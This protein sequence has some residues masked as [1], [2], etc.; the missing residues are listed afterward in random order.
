MNFDKYDNSIFIV[1]NGSKKGIIKKIRKTSK[2]LN[3]KVLSLTELKKKWY[4]DYSKDAI[5]YVSKKYSV[6]SE[7]AKIYI[8]NLYYAKEIDDEKMSFL[9]SLKKELD[10]NNL[11]KTSPLF[12]KFMHDKTIVLYDLDNVDSF[13]KNIFNKLGKSNNVIKYSTSEEGTPKELY[14]ASNMFEEVA[15]VTSSIVKLVKNGVDINN[16][17][18]ANV[19]DEY[20]FVI[21]KTFKDF[22]IPVVLPNKSSIIGTIIVK[23]FIELYSNNMSMVFENLSELVKD[24][25]DEKIYQSLL[26]II[27]DYSW[28]DNYNNVKDMLLSDIA[29]IKLPEKKLKNAVRVIDFLNDFIEEDTH[30]F[31]INF[32]QGVLP[33]DHKDEDYLSDELKQKIGIS[34]SIELNVKDIAETQK[35][36]R[37]TKN[38]VVTYSKHSLSSELYIS[39]AYSDDLFIEKQI[40][41]DYTLSNNYNKSLLTS[42]LDNYK[43]YGKVTQDLNILYN[44]YKEFDYCSYNSEYKGIEKNKIQDKLG[45]KLVLS[46]TSMNTYYECAFKYYLEYILKMNKFEDSFQI[47]IGNI[48]HKILSVAFTD[49]FDFDY[50]WNKTIEEC[51]Y[52]FSNMEKFFLDNLKQEL[53]L[54]IDTI[55]NQLEYTT[56]KNAL[57]EEEV[58][59]E[60]DKNINLYFKGFIDKILYKEED[61]V[62]YVVIID[63]KT[64]NTD[65]SLAGIPHGLNMQL[66]VYIYLLKNQKIIKNVRIGGFYLQRILDDITDR[67]K[68]LDSLKLIGYSNSDI[69]VLSKVDSSYENSKVIKSLK[70]T[71][72]GFSSYSKLLS[73]NEMDKLS[74]IV[75]EKIKGAA[76]NI[77]DA[78]FDINPKELDG[79]L[80]GCNF[81]K[82]KDICFMKNENIVKLKGITKEELFG[83]ELDA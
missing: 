36:I 15:F 63:Y 73:D 4:F 75:S 76:E 47:V 38:L 29:K 3:I 11:L 21:E 62:T 19:S 26:N 83:G 23:K 33:V 72:T 34:T 31:L 46:Y 64:G 8:E 77:N 71:S 57:Y 51:D 1:K 56:L 14:P 79:K 67:E 52:T 2:L 7:V 82:Y 60:V 32:N 48:F 20:H 39:N 40:D 13:Y 37:N 6:I 54:V 80:V 70:T 50:C 18:L 42:L 10:S 81:C 44:H 65:L 30:V 28:C 69:S 58:L 74:C 78:K 22:N 27:N 12:H 49:D 55:N 35:K 16:I 25:A 43:K 68:R 66:P 41:T 5:Y 17:A 24:D 45:N 61:G 9:C 59:V 53:M